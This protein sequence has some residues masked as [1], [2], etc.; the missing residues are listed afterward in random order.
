YRL[1]FFPLVLVDKLVQSGA[2]AGRWL[3]GLLDGSRETDR[4]TRQLLRESGGTINE[5][6]GTKS[7]EFVKALAAGRCRRTGRIARFEGDRV[8]FQDGSEFEPEVVILCTG[9]E[10]RV[11]F[12]NDELAGADRF[13]HTFVPQV[14]ADL[15][16]IGF[17]RP[18]FG[19]IPPLAELQA[20][21]FARLL[22]GEAELPPAPEMVA[23]IE[24]LTSF[25]RDYFRA[26]RGRLDYL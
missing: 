14:G 7:D 13:F 8:V 15:A 1:A 26:V 21:W 3:R 17:L 23:S 2:R 19:A 6:F 22:S 12:L 11:P 5:Q 4:L 9:F 24:R 16:L 25:R 20:R 10:V 18:A